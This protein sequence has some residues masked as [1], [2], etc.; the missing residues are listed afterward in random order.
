MNSPIYKKHIHETIK[1]RR[2]NAC[3]THLCQRR[4]YST[5][6]QNFNLR[7][8][9]EKISYERRA[10]ESVEEKKLSYAMSRKTM[11]KNPGTNGL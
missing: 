4:Q 7:R 10:Y 5:F 9:S 8:D 1:N 6:D 2:P 3:L 11:K